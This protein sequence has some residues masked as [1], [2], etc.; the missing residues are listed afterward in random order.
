MLLLMGIQ[1]GALPLPHTDDALL[2]DLLWEVA[3]YVEAFGEV[4]L[5]DLPVGTA[6]NGLLVQ[7]LAEPGVTVTAIANRGHKAQQTI[8]QMVA[9]LEKLALLERRV[10]AGRSI[11]LYLTPAGR[12]V[13]KQALA[14]ERQVDADV[15]ERL[16]ADRYARLRRLLI[17]CRH[18]LKSAG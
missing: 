17:E 14:R 7:I 8:S 4:A 18:Q 16:G 3:G 1:D 5:A 11:G 9:R 6:S 10:G 13:A 12:D 15:R 2:G